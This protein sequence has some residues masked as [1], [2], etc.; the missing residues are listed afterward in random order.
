MFHLPTPKLRPKPSSTSASGLKHVPA[1]PALTLAQKYGLVAKPPPRLSVE[2]WEEA[3]KRSRA[4]RDSRLPCPI[5]RDEFRDG[6]QVLLSCSHVFHKTCLASFERYAQ[7]KCCPL[8]RTKHYQKIPIR[9][10]A[11]LYQYTSATRIQSYFRG[12]VVRKWYAALLA[13]IP[14]TDPDKRR[15]FFANKLESASDR[16]LLHLEAERDEIDALFAEIDASVRDS[17]RIYRQAAGLPEPEVPEELQ[18]EPRTEDVGGDENVEPPGA[19]SPERDVLGESIRTG[20]IRGSDWDVAVAKAI[21]RGDSDCPICIAPL[22]RAKG[23]STLAWLSCSHVFH[24]DCIAAFED[25]KNACAAKAALT[26]DG[27]RRNRNGER[28][29]S[30]VKHNCPVCRSLYE[31]MWM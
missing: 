22:H 2:E 13:S 20:W 25:Y 23:D 16:L 11:E 26:E 4:R 31:R 7:Q 12:Y 19:G 27:G 30:M 28:V 21:E 6:E 5:C 29:K 17:K 3:H 10:G 18:E 1:Q 14:P 15:H 9:D 24:A 8:C